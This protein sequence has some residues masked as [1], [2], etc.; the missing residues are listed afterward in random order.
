MAIPSNAATI[1]NSSTATATRR[2]AATAATLVRPAIRSGFRQFSKRATARRLQQQKQLTSLKSSFG[3]VVT[4]NSGSGSGSNGSDKTDWISVISWLALE[5]A[6]DSFVGGFLSGYVLGSTVDAT[7]RIYRHLVTT[8][9]STTTST[10][11][12]L[13][14]ILPYAH[15]TQFTQQTL[16]VHRVGI[17]WAKEW[18]VISALFCACR[19]L[20]TVVAS[21][22]GVTC[23]DNG[24][25]WLQQTLETIQN[26]DSNE[27]AW[28]TI[29][30]SA[31]AGAILSRPDN[32]P[33]LRLLQNHKVVIMTMARGAIL[34]GGTM[35][36][37][38]PSLWWNY[39]GRASIHPKTN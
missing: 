7:K 15:V 37:L 39:T 11:S 28:N 31:L 17:A 3:N 34:Y 26:E 9:T 14:E 20:V 19:I 25:T 30:G 12:H 27:N 1:I 18:A 13:Q 22:H 4:N 8:S 10:T 32:T 16:Q 5:T 35:F 24:R 36:L 6:L 21:T 33:F 2:R 23:Q 29:G 38:H